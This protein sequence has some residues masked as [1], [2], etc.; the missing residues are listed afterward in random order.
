MPIARLVT[1][2]AILLF[3]FAISVGVTFLPLGSVRSAIS[4][5]IAAIKAALIAWFFMRMRA[6]S[7]LVRLAAAAALFMLLI[8]FLLTGSD[9]LTRGAG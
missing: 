9:Y 5:T 1:I 2:W 8:A 4:L 6:E 3:I 7:G